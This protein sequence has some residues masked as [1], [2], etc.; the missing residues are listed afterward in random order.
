MIKV[1]HPVVDSKD[2]DVWHQAHKLEEG[3]MHLLPFG[4]LF[5]HLTAPEGGIKCF[6]LALTQKL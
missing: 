6:P 3:T 2:S 4:Q 1:N 5:R